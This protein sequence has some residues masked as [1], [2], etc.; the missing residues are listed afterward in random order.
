MFSLK[1]K[2]PFVK[3]RI[4][5]SKIGVLF[6]IAFAPKANADILID[7]TADTLA[8]GV[9]P[10]FNDQGIYVPSASAAVG[11]TLDTITLVFSTSF[12]PG[13]GYN[14]GNA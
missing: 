5:F 1:T 4:I 2:I 8:G 6:L 12:G 13:N 14:A 7:N 10:S 3:K 11:Q 9:G